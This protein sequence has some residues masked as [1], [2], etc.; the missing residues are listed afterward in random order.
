MP[1]N[2]F[3]NRRSRGATTSRPRALFTLLGATLAAGT[4]FATVFAS[5]AGATSGSTLTIG[6]ANNAHSVVVH[7]GEH[8]TL[9]LHSTYWSVATLASSSSMSQIG[10]PVI[11][12]RLPSAKGGCV[13][14][15]GCGT[16]SVHYVAKTP[17]I[18]H[19]RASRTSCGEALRCTPAQSHWTVTIRVR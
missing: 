14:G 18:V 6:E 7:T 4:M 16:V 9:V 3:F 17:G 11:A 13:A 8:V 5:D 12:P 19:L 15:Q 10:S 2:S 1:G